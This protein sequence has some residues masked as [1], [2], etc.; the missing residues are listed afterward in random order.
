MVVYSLPAGSLE[1]IT[2]KLKHCTSA[3]RPAKAGTQ[4]DRSKNRNEWHW[5]PAY[6]GTN[7]PDAGIRKV[8]YRDGAMIVFW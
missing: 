4:G 3:V 5:V 1:H 6:P 2:M 8:L 7:G